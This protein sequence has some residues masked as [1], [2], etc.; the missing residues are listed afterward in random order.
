ME[1]IMDA[2]AFTLLTIGAATGSMIIQA[3]IF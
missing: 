3:L 1:Y 2:I